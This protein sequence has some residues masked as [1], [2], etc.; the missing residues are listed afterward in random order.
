VIIQGSGT[1]PDTGP[2]ENYVRLTQ[3]PYGTG[4]LDVSTGSNVIRLERNTANSTWI[5]VVTVVESVTDQATEGFSLLD[6]QAVAHTGTATAGTDTSGTAW[7]DINDVVLFGGF[8]GA[9]CTTADPDPGDIGNCQTR[10]YPTGTNTINWT[11]DA[12]NVNDVLTDATS[13]VMVVEWGSSWTVQ[14]VY[15]TGSAGGDKIDEL[16]EYNTAAISPVARDNTW[17]WGTGHQPA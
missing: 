8:N 9:G 2:D 5:G 14:H 7:S 1:L 10:L 12:A 4:D 3:D 6:V 17:V 16:G 11:R 13:T 15:V